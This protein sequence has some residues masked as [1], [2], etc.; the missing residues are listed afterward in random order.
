MRNVAINKV[1]LFSTYGIHLNGGLQETIMWQKTN[2]NRSSQR[3]VYHG[4][5]YKSGTKQSELWLLLDADLRSKAQKAGAN[6]QAQPMQ[7]YTS[8]S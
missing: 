1:A 7:G 4:Y 3:G 6:K 2:F 8:L 5:L